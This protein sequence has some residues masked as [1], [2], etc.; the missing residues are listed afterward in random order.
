MRHNHRL[1]ALLGMAMIAFTA[2]SAHG[3]APSVASDHP[4]PAL[5]APPV[6]ALVTLQDLMLNEV[7]ASADAI[8]DATGSITTS[9]GTID[10]R[11]RT[12]ADWDA[13]RRHAIVLLESTNLLVIPD[14]KVTDA[15]FPSDGPGV[16]SSA[17][18]QQQIDANRS[19]FNGLA[20]GLRQVAR[21]QLE[22]IDR[23][24][25]DALLQ[26]GD[27]MDTACEACHRVNWY[28]NEVVP[29]LPRDPPPPAST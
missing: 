2:C 26:L 18:I 5:A 17:Q 16:F 12:D 6:E 15:P 11:P 9:A 22:A 13:L 7:D 25:V 19:E 29:A 14:R 4:A 28:P 8:W 24:D 1:T 10:R 20:L 3:P 21:A 27:A 23:R